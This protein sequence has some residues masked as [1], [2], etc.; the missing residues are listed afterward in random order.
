M[1]PT[2]KHR[3][4][5]TLIELLVVIAIIAIL[6]AILLP[7]VQQARE[8]ARRSTCKNN[9][10][11]IGLAIHNYESTHGSV[12]PGR[13][14]WLKPSGTEIVMNGIHTYLFPF[15]EQGNLE[16]I[17]DYNLGY[18]DPANQPAV[19]THVPTYVCPSTPNRPV[20]MQIDNFFNPFYGGPPTPDGITASATDYF[21]VRN[22]RNGAGESL[23][24]FFGLP[25]PQFRDITDGLSNT[26]WF[27]EIAGRPDHFINGELQ[28][29]PPASFN[30]Y[31]PWAGNNGMALNTYTADGLNRPG[32]CVMNCNSQF[33]PYAFHAGGSQFG[34]AD[35]SIKFINEN[36]NPDVFRALGSPQGG[37]VIGEF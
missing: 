5:F 28:A 22:V 26:F 14:I 13:L 16:D 8:A 31:G 37:E 4:G 24:G 1:Q 30:G 2:S 18:D 6:V 7:A 27:V 3:T 21:A 29:T 32:P 34:F 25:N 12:A 17:Y 35:G 9:L 19:N 11:Q 15:L 33:Q 23:N 20:Q 10:K 36:I